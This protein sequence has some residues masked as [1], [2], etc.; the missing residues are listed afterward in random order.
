MPLHSLYQ[1]VTGSVALSEQPGV[2]LNS[3]SVTG[4]LV[5]GVPLSNANPIPITGSISVSAQA[6]S[7][8][9]G[10]TGSLAPVSASLAGF[11]DPNGNLQPSRV[12]DQGHQIVTG[13]V[14]IAGP[15]AVTQGTSPWIVSGSNW[16]PTV[17]GSVRVENT[18]N[19]IGLSGSVAGLLVGGEAVSNANPVPVTGSVSI[20]SAVAVT[21]GT[22]PWIIS[23]SAWTPTVTGSVVVSNR[24][25]VQEQSSG[26][27]VTFVTSS[28]SS[29]VTFAADTPARMGIIVYNATN[30][31]F[32][33]KLGVSASLDDYTVQMAPDE[34]WE[35]PFG[36]RGR[37]DGTSA[38]GG[39]LTGVIRIT[40]LT[41]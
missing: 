2:L 31:I 32:Y 17:T 12:S 1:N 9:V 7:P 39:S 40:E 10:A 37:I 33:A 11:V 15:V 26:S 24:V 6:V 5:G 38:P 36:Y 20:A 25:F 22:S 18:V 34:T 35:V 13:S 23:G 30:K 4:L 3:G 19:V 29:S 21:Q 41:V 28:N 27:A 14:G 16:I 8:D